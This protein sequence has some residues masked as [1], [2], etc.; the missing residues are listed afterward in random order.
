M[1]VQRKAQSDY[2]VKVYSDKGS[3]SLRFPKRHSGV[4]ELL[5]GKSLKGKALIV[6][7]S[8]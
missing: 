7:D 2:D 1:N 8:A 5:D 4:W 3:L 6:P